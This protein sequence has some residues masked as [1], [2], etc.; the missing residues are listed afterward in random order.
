MTTY[1]HSAACSI[2]Q[3]VS[4]AIGR[5]GVLPVAN[6]IGRALA[7]LHVLKVIGPRTSDNAATISTSTACGGFCGGSKYFASFRFDSGERT[8]KKLRSSS[9]S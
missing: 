8:T 2:G 7:G 3:S 5:N 4:S 1:F 6:S 9:G